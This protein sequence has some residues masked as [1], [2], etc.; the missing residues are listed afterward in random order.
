MTLE[1]IYAR[2]AAEQAAAMAD[3]GEVTH[4]LSFAGRR[5]RVRSAGAPIASALTAALRHRA[6]AE[7][8]PLDA[9]ILL[10]EESRVPGGALPAPWRP[11][12]LGP[13]GLA[14]AGERGELGRPGPAGAGEKGELLA[15][16]EDIWGGIMICDRRTRVALNRVPD[17]ARLPWWERPA[18]LRPALFGT[19]TGGG[20]HLVHAGAVG[21]ERGGVLLAGRGGSGKTTV[22]LAALAAGMNY[23]ADDYL[24]LEDGEQPLAWNVFGTAKLEAGH[25][26]RFPGFAGELVISPDPEPQEKFVLDIDRLMG[27]AISECL[28]I[29]AVLVPRIRG[30]RAR[31]R[32]ASAVEALLALAPSTTFQMPFDGG[33]VIGALAA[34]TR[35]V[36]AYALDVGDDPR[37][38]A[39]AVDR[40]LDLAA[41][42][43]P[44]VRTPGAT[45][46]THAAT[47]PGASA[48]SNTATTAGA[49]R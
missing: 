33:E 30:G 41:A 3:T 42:R 38:L 7:E 26:E 49:R 44:A 47:T 45:A 12:E 4:T 37:E 18:P 43:P 19:L 21:D 27:E 6:C 14:G 31:L 5:V 10:W 8:G 24:L 23:V 34:V 20:L 17:A 16:Y 15:I 13:R 36:P 40:A 11:G 28:P 39:E 25:A 9:T 1:E 32:E 29:R 35:A 22:A 46:R 2:F 48:L